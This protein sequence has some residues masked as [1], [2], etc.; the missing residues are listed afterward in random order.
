MISHPTLA[1][2][3]RSF[4]SFLTAMML[5]LS[6]SNT[7]HSKCLPVLDT[8]IHIY[9]VIEPFPDEP[10]REDMFPED[11][12]PDLA[13]MMLIENNTRQRREEQTQFDQY[14]PTIQN[15]SR[16]LAAVIPEVR[17]GNQVWSA[18][19]LDVVCF[20]NGDTIPQ[21][22]SRDE[23]ARASGEGRPM[24][25]YPGFAK[26]TN[27]PGSRLYNGYAIIDKRGLAPIGWRVA[28]AHDWDTLELTLM[29][30]GNV[31]PQ[32]KTSRGW[33]LA[34]SPKRGLPSGKIDGNGT[35]RS[36]LNIAPIDIEFSAK[37]SFDGIECGK[38]IATFYTS[39]LYRDES[40]LRVRVVSWEDGNWQ[41]DSWEAQNGYNNIRHVA[42]NHVEMWHGCSVRCVRN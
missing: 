4:R 1:S 15:R 39:T 6:V 34:T 5:L 13:L 32:I 26:S 2:L 27:K 8:S 38:D 7:V 3:L 30:Y 22:L 42:F 14:P 33:P 23:W 31:A 37:Y 25:C 40:K 29:P 10:R 20:R 36:K 12:D 35:N 9:K 28:T 21:A 19:N 24:W 16:A 41:S 18:Q 17:I 11:Y